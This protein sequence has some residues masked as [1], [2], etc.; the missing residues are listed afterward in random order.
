M[1]KEILI[2]IIIGFALGLVI[3]FGVWTANRAMS[4]NDPIVEEDL[5]GTEE[6]TPKA[7]SEKTAIS[8]AINSPEDES[9]IT[10]ST[11]ALN[12]TTEPDAQV[13]IVYET[14]ETIIQADQKGEFTFD[15]PLELGTNEI[16]ITVLSGEE[17]ISKTLSLVYS[18]D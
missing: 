4:K 8:L 7:N 2:A 15:L 18:K 6:I 14:G 9:L 13:A 16:K 17:K 1:R 3:T 10:T 5:G 12:G 11:V